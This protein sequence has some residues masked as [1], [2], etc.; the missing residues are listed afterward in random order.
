MEKFFLF[1]YSFSF[2]YFLVCCFFL[3]FREC[4]ARV[5]C[6]GWWCLFIPWHTHK[7]VSTWASYLCVRESSIGKSLALLGSYIISI[8]L[9]RSLKFAVSIYGLCVCVYFCLGNRTSSV[10]VCCLHLT[11]S[12]SFLALHSR[13]SSLNNSSSPFRYSFDIPHD[14]KQRRTHTLNIAKG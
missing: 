9:M 8:N 10:L 14:P 1:L 11:F 4:S 12:A 3:V 5:Q 13:F 2:I 7:S 6:S